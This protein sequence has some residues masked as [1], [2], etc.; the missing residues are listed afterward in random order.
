MK[1]KRISKITKTVGSLCLLFCVIFIPP[2]VVSFIY[3]DGTLA[4][5][6]ESFF[7]TL[8]IGIT[9]WIP[10]REKKVELYQRDGF[11]IIVLVW[12]ALSLLSSIPFDLI[13]HTSIVD[14]LFEAVSGITTTGATVLTGLDDMPPSLLFYRQELQWFG[15]MGLIVLAVAVIPQLGIG[16]MSIYKAEVPGIMKEEKLTPRLHKT[17]S[18]LWKM[19]LG[20]TLSC[21]LAFWLAGMNIFDA[22]SHSLATVSTGGFSTHDKSMG[23]FENGIIEGIAI[24]FMI[25]GAIN[26]SLHFV[27]IKNRS[28]KNYFFNE[29]VR[30]FIMIVLGST[31]II[32]FTLLEVFDGYHHVFRTFLNSSFT[33]VSFITSTG[34]A[35]VDYSAWPT[36]IPFFLILIGFVGG[37]GGSTAGGMKVIRILI[38]F[39]LINR[40]MKRL[41]HPK[42]IFF[43]R[44]NGRSKIQERTLQSVFGFFALYVVAFS[45]LLLL[46][47]ADGVDQ[48][49][50]FSAIATCMNN[51]GPGLGEVTSSFASLDDS[52][53]IISV[54]SMLI[55]RLEV[56][57]VLILLSPEYWKA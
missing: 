31:L 40:E 53:K 42:G 8:L 48:I 37:C 41:L 12:L 29:E 49:T 27:A 36:F 2:M 5:F 44:V 30:L 15:G 6:T 34:F 38:L 14:S 21:A 17:A 46:M 19:Y 47:M 11:L 9:M 57:S 25:L 52:A 24:I 20:L 3:H 33:V 23:Y 51:M 54:A 50:A 55:G 45:S 56:V 10:F 13:L 28:L 26:F 39:K 18:T 1:L 22:L 32:A 43:I 35:T 4:Q 16:G 7:I